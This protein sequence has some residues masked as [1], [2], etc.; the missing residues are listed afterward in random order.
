YHPPGGPGVRLDTHVYA[1]YRVPPF[2]DSLIAKLIVSGNSREEA[3]VRAREALDSFVIEGISTTIG[4][5]SEITRDEE[6][7]SGQIDTGF[8][9]RFS[10]RRA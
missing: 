4:Y 6:F 5:L 7:R 10:K 2:Y 8:V 1:G 3:L 9:E